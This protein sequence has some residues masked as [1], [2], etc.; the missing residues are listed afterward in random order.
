MQIIG[1]HFSSIESEIL[2]LVLIYYLAINL[3][4]KQQNLLTEN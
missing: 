3:T 4:K 1:P 2:R